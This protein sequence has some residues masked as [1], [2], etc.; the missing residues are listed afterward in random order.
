M[1]KLNITTLEDEVLKTI[2]DENVDK[3][4]VENY[5]FPTMLS[6][7]KGYICV[8]KWNIHGHNTSEGR[9]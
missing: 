7:S 2:G 6:K 8:E 4:L 3:V 1:E 5:K 9:P